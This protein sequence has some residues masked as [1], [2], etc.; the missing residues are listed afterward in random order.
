MGAAGPPPGFA[1]LAIDP[2]TSSSARR[3][4]PSYGIVAIV[5]DIARKLDL[6]IEKEILPGIC[7]DLDSMR[8]ALIDIKARADAILPTHDWNVVPGGKPEGVA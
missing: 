1:S 5:G 3:R 8:R 4:S 7:H 6:N 2:P